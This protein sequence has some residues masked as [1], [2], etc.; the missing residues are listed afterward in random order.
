[1]IEGITVNDDCTGLAGL[2]DI[3]FTFDETEYVLTSDDYVLKVTQGGQT[4]CVLAIMPADFPA[5]FNYF[6]LGDTFMRKFYS[7]FDKNNN[8]VGFI[9]ST[10]LSFPKE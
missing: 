10:K 4:E 1:M 6:I 8:R 3:A 5:G 2:P 7:F 9:N